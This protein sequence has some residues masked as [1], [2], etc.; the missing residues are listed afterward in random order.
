MKYNA[1]SGLPPITPLQN[2]ISINFYNI[3]KYFFYGPFNPNR[4]NTIKATAFLTLLQFEL[5]QIN[6][7]D[8]LR[9]L[10]LFLPSSISLL[11]L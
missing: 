2:Y 11:K 9:H 1:F 5:G 10:Q 3:A 7:V 4:L 8:L 6:S